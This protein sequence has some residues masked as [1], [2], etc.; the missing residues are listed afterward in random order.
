MKAQE[1]TSLLRVYMGH[2]RLGRRFDFSSLTLYKKNKYPICFCS[3]LIEAEFKL[4]QR[5]KVS[6]N[7]ESSLYQE[8]WDCFAN[9]FC[10][11]VPCELNVE[12]GSMFG[13]NFSGTLGVKPGVAATELK[14]IFEV[15]V[16]VSEQ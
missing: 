13:I 15:L 11:N 10:T 4:G 1:Y 5:L 12:F 16:F 8:I 3:A 14:E 2:H 6:N 9:L 7:R